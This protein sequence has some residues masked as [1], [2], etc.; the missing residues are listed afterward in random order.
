VGREQGGHGPGL[1]FRLIRERPSCLELLSAHIQSYQH[2]IAQWNA[3]DYTETSSVIHYPGE[4]LT[5]YLNTSFETLK[6]RQQQLIY[7]LERKRGQPYDQPST[8]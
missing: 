8:T 2:V 5:S 6:A 3:G 7:T 4:K 1:F